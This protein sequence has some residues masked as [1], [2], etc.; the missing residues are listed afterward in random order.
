MKRRILVF[1]SLV[2]V[3]GIGGFWLTGKGP[4]E[5]QSSPQGAHPLKAINDKAR[6]ARAGSISD[7]EDYVAEIIRVA[8]FEGELN[9]FTATA[10]KDRVGRAESRYRQGQA[11]GI[12]EAKIVRTVNG[13]ARKFDLP[14]YVRTSNYEVRRLRLGLLPNFP[15]IITQETQGVLPVSVGAQIDSQM[16]PAE[17]VFVLAMMLQQKMVN[18]EYQLRHSERLD[19]WAETHNHSAPQS[20]SPHPAQNRS[21]EIREALTRAASSA[22][23]SDSLSLSNLTLNTL[24]IEQ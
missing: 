14:D 20:N 13:L 19:R 21:R 22:S 1:L 23:M 3:I 8:G 9:G 16:S 12:P 7:A 2:V 4:V 11:A 15:Q 18:T 10:I 5:A 24:G 6:A 17:A